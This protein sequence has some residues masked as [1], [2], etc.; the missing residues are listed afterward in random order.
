MPYDTAK[1]I[2][3]NEYDMNEGVKCLCSTII[4]SILIYLRSVNMNEYDMNE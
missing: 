2:Y 3:E 1:C 4:Y